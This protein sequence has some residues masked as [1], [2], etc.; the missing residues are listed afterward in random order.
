MILGTSQRKRTLYVRVNKK[1]HWNI[2]YLCS[3]GGRT[4][5]YDLRVMSPTSYQL[6]HPAMFL[7]F[8]SVKEFLLG[9]WSY[10]L[11]YGRTANCSTPRCFFPRFLQSGMQMY[12]FSLELQSK[13][14]N[15]LPEPGI[16]QYLLT[17][18]SLPLNPISGANPPQSDLRLIISSLT[19]C[20]DWRRRAKALSPWM[21]SPTD[22]LI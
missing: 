1:R 12:P 3:S 11:P 19:H 4:W 6:L 14:E 2:Q 17:T 5:T 22:S 9:T 10:D 20:W 15:H 7:L 16:V 13:R 18:Y 8:L 21:A